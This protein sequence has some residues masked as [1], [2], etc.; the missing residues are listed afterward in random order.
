MFWLINNPEEIKM[1]YIEGWNLTMGFK[2][3]DYTRHKIWK[4]HY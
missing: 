4:M 1:E 3:K 2:Q